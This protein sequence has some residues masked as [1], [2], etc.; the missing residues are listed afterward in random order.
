MDKTIVR[1]FVLWAMKASASTADTRR[2]WDEAFALYGRSE[3]GATRAGL[4]EEVAEYD[5][6]LGTAHDAPIVAAL[7]R[8]RCAILASDEAARA[9]QGAIIA[10]KLRDTFAYAA[11]L[12]FKRL[13]LGSGDR[14]QLAEGGAWFNIVERWMRANGKGAE[15]DAVRGWLDP[16]LADE[17]RTPDTAGATA[18]L[19]AMKAAFSLTRL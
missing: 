5:A 8:G 2:S 18:A 4:S 11:G 6:D 19:N 14:V 13:S 1:F 3:D 17:S 7:V 15:A 16:L 12:Y 9:A 10:D